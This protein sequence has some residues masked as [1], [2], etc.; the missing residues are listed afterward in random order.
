MSDLT[1]AR[2]LT[3][4]VVRE[5]ESLFEYQPWDEDQKAR[6]KKVRNALATACAVIIANVPPCPDRTV[7]I[8]KLRECRMDCNSGISFDG[9]Y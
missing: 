6:G 3:P 1:R 4:E 2:E 8:R 7:A 5:L 9:K